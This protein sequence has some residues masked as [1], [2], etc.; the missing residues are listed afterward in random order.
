[1]PSMVGADGEDIEIDEEKEAYYK[2]DPKK[3]LKKFF[4]REGL[5]FEYETEEEGPPRARVYTVRVRWVWP[6]CG[7]DMY[8]SHA[9]Q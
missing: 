6:G 7:L 1:M 9:E 4:D 8:S 5:E 2:D 3:A